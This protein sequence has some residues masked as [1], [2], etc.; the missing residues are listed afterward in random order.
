MCDVGVCCVLFCVMFFFSSRRRHT[1]CALVTGVQT[2]ALPI[3]KLYMTDYAELAGSDHPLARKS[4]VLEL[5]RD[6]AFTDQRDRLT[7]WYTEHRFNRDA[8]A[9]EA[10]LDRTLKRVLD[11]TRLQDYLD[12]LEGDI[13]RMH[14]RMLA[15]IDYRLHAPSHLEVRIKRAIAGVKATEHYDVGVPAG[16]GQI[17]SGPGLYEPRLKRTPIPRETDRTRR[18]SPRGEALMRLQRRARSAR[19]A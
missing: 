16:P 17:L 5:A 3:C 11:L 8:T 2:C 9:A 19:S 14:R 18:M 10:H 7:M 4:H 1:R 15:L 12:R 13:R 6:M